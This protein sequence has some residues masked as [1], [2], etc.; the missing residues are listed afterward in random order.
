M[1]KRL[2]VVLGL[3]VFAPSAFSDVPEGCFDLRTPGR[4]APLQSRLRGKAPRS[5][6][7]KSGVV[8]AHDERSISRSVPDVLSDLLNHDLTRSN[9]SEVMIESIPDKNFLVRQRV[10]LEVN[11]FPFVTVRWKEDWF[12]LVMAGTRDRPERILVGYQKAEGTPYIQHLCGT[13]V[14]KR[15]LDGGARVSVYEEV[16]ATRRSLEDT[17]RGIHATLDRLAQKP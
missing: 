11:P 15:E 6:R 8:W 17:R 13:Y 9:E 12:V 5:G 3:L 1:K 4:L 7:F 16:L 2:A 10:R 14:L